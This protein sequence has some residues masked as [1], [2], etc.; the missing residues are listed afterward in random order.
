MGNTSSHR[1]E[2][3]PEP[4]AVIGGYRCGSCGAEYPSLYWFRREAGS[5]KA[6]CLECADEWPSE[7]SEPMSPAGRRQTAGSQAYAVA[8]LMAWLVSDLPHFL[9]ER[10]DV[11]RGLGPLLSADPV[12]SLAGALIGFVAFCSTLYALRYISSRWPQ[13]HEFI[14]GARGSPR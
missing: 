2:A 6:F 11:F 9:K 4:E 14:H 5:E 1:A 3:H 10:W 13:T 7:G 12:L 8:F